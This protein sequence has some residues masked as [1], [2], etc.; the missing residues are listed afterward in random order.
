MSAEGQLAQLQHDLQNE[1]TTSNQLLRLITIELQ[2]IKALTRPGGEFEANIK[3]NA[4]LLKNLA[5]I[6]KLDLEK[7]P[8]MKRVQIM[9]TTQNTNPNMS[10]EQHDSFRDS[11][12]ESQ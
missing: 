1:L 2:K 3:Q 9:D 10:Y 7:V 8:K 5:S 6:Q 4:N 11:M 12:E